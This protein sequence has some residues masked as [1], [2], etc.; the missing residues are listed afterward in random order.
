MRETSSHYASEGGIQIARRAFLPSNSPPFVALILVHGLGDHTER[1]REALTD[2]VDSGVA[3][4]GAD[5]PG[6]GYSGGKRGHFESFD[7]LHGIIDETIDHARGEIPAEIPLGI[8]A[9]SMGGLITLDLLRKNTDPFSFAWISAT[10]IDANWN[11]PRI[12][13]PIIRT[14]K[15]FLPGMTFATGV[16]PAKLYPDASTPSPAAVEKS[17]RRISV[18]AA[19]ELLAARDRIHRDM[20]SIPVDFP[21]LFTHGTDDEV[22]PHALAQEFFQTL[23]GNGE[24]KTFQSYDGVLHEP[25]RFPRVRDAVCAW[26]KSLIQPQK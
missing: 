10:L 23:P 26:I 17:H 25:W 4:F 24:T 18:N 14:A 7:Q 22:C 20:H 15:H 6:H 12:L 11:R 1:Y 21:I 13:S 8:F 5:F 3:I 19:Y 2:L 9:H 16:E